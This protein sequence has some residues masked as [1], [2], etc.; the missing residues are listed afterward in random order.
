MSRRPALDRGFTLVE[1]MVSLVMGLIIALAVVGLAQTATTTFYEQ[2]RLSATEGAVRTSVERLRN[3][4]MRVSYMVTGNIKADPNVAKIKDS[5]APWR[6]NE[7]RDLQGLRVRVGQSPA[8][9]D[10]TMQFNGMKPDLVEV[11]G[12]LTSDDSYAGV[13]EMGGTCAGGGQ[14]VSLDARSDAAVRTLFNGATDVAGVE[15]AVKAA[16]LPVDGK[17][18]IVQVMDGTGCYHYAPVCAVNV[19]DANRVEIHIEGDSKRAVLY[20]NSPGGEY[21]NPPGVDRNCGSGNGGPVNI[22]PVMRAR[23]SIKPTVTSL[24]PD[25]QVE[26]DTG[27]FDLVRELLDFNG[28]VIGSEVIAEYAIDLRIGIVV[29]DPTVVAGADPVKVFDMDTATAAQIEA[30]TGPGVAPVTPGTPV[31]GPHRIRSLRFR[32]AARTG[33]P[34]RRAPITGMPYA[35]RYCVDNIAVA[36]C[37][38]FARVRSLTSEVAMMNQSRMFY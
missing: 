16:F 18:F 10:T 15:K 1:L 8:A 31:A 5:P 29:D 12:N 37:K 3:D 20:A 36:S 22:A 26:P 14:K 33:N 9:T 25:P 11:T 21:E 6:Y 24:R 2:A 28:T 13:I 17:K 19:L 23:W 38:R 27:K 32:V 7:L 30:Y 4:L 34:D 35:T